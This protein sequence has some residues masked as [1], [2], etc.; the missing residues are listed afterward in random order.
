MKFYSDPI[1]GLQ[2]MY[3]YDDDENL[4]IYKMING[5]WQLDS[6]VIR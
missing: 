5:I 4:I 3:F 1:N 2:L 6:K